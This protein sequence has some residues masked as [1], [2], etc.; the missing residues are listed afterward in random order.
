MS[1]LIAEGSFFRKSAQL[2]TAIV[3]RRRQANG[4]GAFRHRSRG[5]HARTHWTSF[6][7]GMPRHQHGLFRLGLRINSRTDCV[8][9]T[10][11]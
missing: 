5:E 7:V 6:V 4:A 9:R 11:A 2:A 8:L 3:F 10:A 1:P